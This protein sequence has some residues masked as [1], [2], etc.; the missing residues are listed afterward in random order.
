MK[1]LNLKD[2]DA[3]VD[4]VYS[5]IDHLITT[6]GH[7]EESAKR[8]FI[9]QVKDGKHIKKSGHPKNLLLA[10]AIQYCDLTI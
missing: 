5:N 1:K 2:N 7:D 4:Y 9:S 10:T 3:A 8:L 6:K